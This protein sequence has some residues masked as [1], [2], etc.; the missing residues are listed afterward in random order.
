MLRDS[1]R[2]YKILR[3]ALRR[4]RAQYN[5]RFM[6]LL[7]I[8]GGGAL[9]RMTTQ[10]A[11]R[12]GVNVAVLDLDENCPAAQVTA[13]GV[14]GDWND[15]ELV[16]EF[17][18]ACDV[19]TVETEAVPVAVLAH[20]EAAGKIVRPSSK[21]LA[22]T[23]DRYVLKQTLQA[24]RLPVTPHV[25]VPDIDALNAFAMAQQAPLVLKTRIGS[26]D[27]SG[28]AKV[29]S[30]SAASAAFAQLAQL[31]APLMA[32]VAQDFLREISV[33][34]VRGQNGAHKMYPAA[35]FR[36]HK[37]AIQCVNAPAPDTGAAQRERHGRQDGAYY[38]DTL[39]A[40]VARVAEALD[41]IGA[42]SIELFEGRDGRLMINSVAPRP[43][44]A[45]LYSID[46]C[47]VSMFENH[48]RAVLGQPLGWTDMAAPYA[49]T[50]TIAARGD[51]LPSVDDF[52]QALQFRGARL[53]WYGKASAAPGRRLGH[54]TALNTSDP[55]AERIAQMFSVAMVGW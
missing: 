34:A 45:G 53:H 10:A 22:L 29:A 5:A 7:G 13:Y 8:L 44:Q 25:E 16:T 15:L 33:A 20:L 28:V 50:V 18:Q 48:A 17:A 6:T 30:A 11:Q 19:V 2:R 55:E 24:A 46:A 41:I 47:D 26:G 40:L 42:F 1:A 3:R 36:L 52:T 9:A 14:G 27:S 49:V 51:S 37:G 32:E 23:R 35:D 4:R 38:F 31:G 12:L 54:V 43:S 21:T 39:D